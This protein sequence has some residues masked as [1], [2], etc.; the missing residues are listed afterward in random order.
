MGIDLTTVFKSDASAKPYVSALVVFAQKNEAAGTQV[1]Q[2]IT[3]HG[4]ITNTVQKSDDETL[5]FVQNPAKG[6]THVVRLSDQMLVTVGG[7]QIPSGWIGEMVEEHG[8]LPDLQTATTL[9]H[10]RLQHTVTKSET[11]QAEAEAALVSYAEYLNQLAVLPT[12]CFKLDEAIKE[13][14]AKC[15]CD[16]EKKDDEDDEE[17]VAKAD[18][19]YK[20]TKL[21]SDKVKNGATKSGETEAEKT[22]RLKNH[23]PAEMAPVDEEDDQKPPPDEAYKSEILDALKGVTT[24]LTGLSTKLETVAAEQVMQKKVLDDVVQKADTV[25]QKLNATVTAPPLAEDRPAGSTR[26]RVQ[27]DDDPRTGTFDTA[28]LRRRNR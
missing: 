11:P 5:V 16:D 1:Q 23:P 26:M 17:P 2:A 4:F 8:F 3:D 15:D 19:P 14:V 24:Q 27:K 21:H 9:L 22:K 6:D 13:I 20:E 12:N 25:A 10:N 7:L 18:S 28:Y